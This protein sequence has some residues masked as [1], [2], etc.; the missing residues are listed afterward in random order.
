MMDREGGTGKTVKPQII[1]HVFSHVFPSLPPPL[2]NPSARYTECFFIPATT[3]GGGKGGKGGEGGVGGRGSYIKSKRQSNLPAEEGMFKTR[4]NF[5]N[6][7]P[8]WNTKGS[9]VVSLRWGRD[10]MTRWREREREKT[11][12]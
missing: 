1:L 5:K 8:L 10:D 3:G 11:W 7:N 6:L 9:F 12:W 4:V 2:L